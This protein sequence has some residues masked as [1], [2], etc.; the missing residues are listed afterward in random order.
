M[1]EERKVTEE[2]LADIKSLQEAYLVLTYDLG[3]LS[4]EKAD[5]EIKL[6]TINQSHTDAIEHLKALR[7]KEEA[8]S[9]ALQEKYGSTTIDLETGVIK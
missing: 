9:Q 8:L 1:T 2:E 6:D 5:L 4:I 3:K 7:V